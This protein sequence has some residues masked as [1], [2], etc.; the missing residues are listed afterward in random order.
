RQR[1][2]GIHEWA[3]SF[4]PVVRFS[5]THYSNQRWQIDNNRL[6]LWVQVWH[7]HQWVHTQALICA[8][9]CAHSRTIPGYILS[10]KAPDA[11]TTALLIM[12]AV[13]EKENPDW[14]NKGLPN[15]LQPDRGKT[16]LAHAVISSLACL[17]VVPDPD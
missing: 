13:A 14:K 3:R 11:W 6:E 16:F 4:C 10:A 1:K 17:G 2:L 8:C 5:L 12:M 15:V 9:M 7:G